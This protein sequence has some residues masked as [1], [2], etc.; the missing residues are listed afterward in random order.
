MLPDVAAEALYFMTRRDLD[1]ACGVSKWL[2]AIIAHCFEVYPLRRVRSVELFPSGNEFTL[3][4]WDN[5][6]W[7]SEEEAVACRGR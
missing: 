6:H 4:V 7:N 5:D 1:K 2:D 3:Q